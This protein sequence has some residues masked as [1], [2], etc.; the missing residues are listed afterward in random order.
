[1]VEFELLIDI[2]QTI[3]GDWVNAFKANP[4]YLLLFTVLDLVFLTWLGPPLRYRFWIRIDGRRSG[5]QSY[6]PEEVNVYIAFVNRLSDKAVTFWTVFTIAIC[7]SFGVILS[8]NA[9]QQGI[10][11]R[12]SPTAAYTAFF[13]IVPYTALVTAPLVLAVRFFTYVMWEL[14]EGKRNRWIEL[15]KDVLQKREGFFYHKGYNGG[16]EWA[17]WELE[18]KNLL[19]ERKGAPTT[20]DKRS[21]WKMLKDTPLEMSFWDILRER[22]VP[23]IYQ[24]GIPTP[25]G[26][27]NHRYLDFALL[28]PKSGVPVLGIEMDEWHHFV[29]WRLQRS[30]ERHDF[31][32]KAHQ[33]VLRE[34]CKKCGNSPCLFMKNAPGDDYERESDIIYAADIPIHRIPEA[35]W[36]RGLDPDNQKLKENQKQ[37]LD[38]A[39]RER[40][41]IIKEKRKQARW[42]WL[43][44][45]LRR[46]G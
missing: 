35:Y 3:L 45:L 46:W 41:R 37:M 2:S 42:R 16:K 18:D 14:V 39:L 4:D 9:F 28:D 13:A 19:T 29:D 11:L 27:K 20:S 36:S 10:V 6:L 43:T 34:K 5:V 40:D 44:R 8:L 17:W 15:R 31:M 24:L 33:G 32:D 25:D 38:A 30:L 22:R 23:H 26:V 12:D 21:A 7:E 1:M